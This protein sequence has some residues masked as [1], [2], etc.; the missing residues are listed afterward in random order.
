MLLLES[1][2][3]KY[4]DLIRTIATFFQRIT[5]KAICILLKGR[6]E[7]GSYFV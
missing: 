5:I 3:I 6:T 2:Y 7:V 4:E 1:L